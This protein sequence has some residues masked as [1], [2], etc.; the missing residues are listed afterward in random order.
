M[1]SCNIGSRDRP[2]DSSTS[3]RNAKTSARQRVEPLRLQHI[4]DSIKDYAIITLDRDGRVASWNRGAERL[5]GYTEDEILGQPG[6]IF[7]T[8]EDRKSGAPECEMQ[9]AREEGRATNERWHVRKDGSRFWGSGLMLPVSDGEPDAYLK[10][11]RD[12]T[13]A[14]RAAERQALLIDELNHRVKNTLAIVQSMAMQTLRSCPSTADAREALESRLVSLAKA[15]D[16]LTSGKWR[17]GDL[18]ELVTGS[19]DAYAG[20]SGSPRFRV[21]GAS[22]RLRPKALLALSMALHELATNAVKYGALRNETGQVEIG[23][24]LDDGEPRRFRFHWKERGGPPVE[25]PRKRGFGSRLV[26]EGLG[27]DIAA[28]VHLNFASEGLECT[29]EAPA[30]EITE[31]G[32]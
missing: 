9:L 29:I 10:I 14:R 16:I 28:H 31:R 11:F 5:L 21:Q 7:F 8:P 17:G 23:W 18:A 25:P 13:E 30:E 27:Q 22:V 1:G 2:D 26:E 20:E 19:L 15:H 12:N 32:G 6:N 3:G 4:L 24:E